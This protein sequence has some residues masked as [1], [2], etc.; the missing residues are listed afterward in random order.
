MNRSLP[1]VL[2]GGISAPAQTQQKI[3]G[4]VT[5]TN[6]DDTVD[7]LMNAENVIIVSLEL[8][9][10]ALSHSSNS[11]RWSA[12]AWPSQRRNMPFRKSLVSYAPRVL[13]SDSPS[14]LWPVECQGNVM[15]F[16]PRR[17]FH[18]IVSNQTPS[19]T[20]KQLTREPKVVLEMD[21]IND[22]FPDTDVT[23]V[24]GANDTVN[25]IALEENSP[26]S[27]MPVLHAWKSKEVIVMKRG[28]ASGYG[29]WL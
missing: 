10:L 3:E 9:R 18:T 15:S 13:M 22:D 7:A 8:H 17:L 19:N 24:I 21:E 27:G 4:Q 12:T 29:M 6:I 26:I 11:T 16:L 20:T 1:N 23:L 14:I 2:F 28:M 5:Q 25:P